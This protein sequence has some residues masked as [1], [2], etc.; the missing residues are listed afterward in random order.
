M[1]GLLGVY[2][3]GLFE[4]LQ[5][6]GIIGLSSQLGLLGFA[7]HTTQLQTLFATQQLKHN[8]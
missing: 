1:L 8:K 4:R 7:K 2:M 6:L 3:L 5:L